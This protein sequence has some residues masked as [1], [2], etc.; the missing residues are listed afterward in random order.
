[1]LQKKISGLENTATDAS[2]MKHKQKRNFKF[3]FKDESIVNMW[4]HFKRLKI[5]IFEAPRG[6]EILEKIMIKNVTNS[7]GDCKYTD[8]LSSTKTKQNK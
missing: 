3:Y 5:H 8:P 4:D 7:D 1:M 2:D 6:W